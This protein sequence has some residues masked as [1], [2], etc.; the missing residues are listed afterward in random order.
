MHQIDY[1]FSVLSPYTYLAGT[2]LEQ[3][4]A[5][6]GATINYK[7]TDVVALFG[8]TGGTPPKD[9]HP[10]RQEYRA[11]ELV[12]WAK[13]LD[14]PFNLKPAYWPTNGAPASYAIIAAIHAGGG[15]VGKLVFAFLRSVW[16][17]EKDIAQDDVVRAC[18]EEAGFSPSLADSGL[19]QGAETYAA[20]L[21]EA[22]NR[23]VFGAPFY[24][25][26]GDNRFWGQDRL[27]DLDMHLAGKL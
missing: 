8:R 25:C 10:S 11:Q 26:E 14:M 20:N 23:G 7:P 9:R 18:L 22:A 6:H 21:E 5:K 16:A 17:D 24:I 1:F 19:L 15:D 12:R 13:K 4:A 2:R 27:D 3:I